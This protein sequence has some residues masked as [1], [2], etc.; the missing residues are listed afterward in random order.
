MHAQ[1]GSKGDVKSTERRGVALRVGAAQRRGW[2]VA[3]VAVVA[4]MFH[5]L[6]RT[7]QI[8]AANGDPLLLGQS[9][10]A[11]V[12]TTLSSSGGGSEGALRVINSNGGA[13]VGQGSGTYSS[14]VGQTSSGLGVHGRATADG[15]GL[16]GDS[17]SGAGVIGVSGT[18]FGVWANSTSGAGVLGNSSTS[19][20]VVGHSNSSFG[21]WGDSG[22]SVPGVLGTSSSGIGV[23][24]TASSLPGVVGT[25]S[26]TFGMW[27]DAP[28]VGV[29]GTA[30]AQD[31]WGVWG[32]VTSGTG[33]QGSS[34]TGIGVVG[35]SRDKWGVWGWSDYGWAGVFSGP[36]FVG[37]NFIAT[38]TK[39]AAVPHPDGSHRRMYAL[40]S[41]ENYFED[42]GEAA[43]VNGVAQ[44]QLDPD[45]AALVN[46]DDYH[47]FLTPYGDSNG[48]YVAKR[49][50]SGFE[51][52]EQQ[53]G[54][55][56]LMFSYRIV[57]RRKDV[58]RVRLEKIALPQLRPQPPGGARALDAQALRRQLELPELPRQP[59]TPRQIPR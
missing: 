36:V 5:K 23:W 32:T 51:V 11:T 3:A 58:P 20:G 49:T 25:S 44:V 37:G 7:E 57:A 19:I 27:G 35:Y 45:F 1:D 21:V 31:G 55:R 43:L 33:V 26:G 42:F 14:V 17:G 52:R 15:V 18:G 29:L 40:E 2:L 38:G 22:G 30:S 4:G 48:L 54:T 59:R 16:W 6:T 9:N 47:V 46:T 13:I 39:S 8:E 34:T 56:S 41:P 28:S 10:T 12:S 53:G 24:G 50:A